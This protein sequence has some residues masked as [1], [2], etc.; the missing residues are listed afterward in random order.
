[1]VVAS[2]RLRA[3]VGGVDGHCSEE[4]LKTP[5]FCNAFVF[6]TG[7]ARLKTLRAFGLVL[8]HAVAAGKHDEHLL[9]H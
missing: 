3:A 8:L 1:M 5:R 7:D 9:A 6:T 4:P 2:S